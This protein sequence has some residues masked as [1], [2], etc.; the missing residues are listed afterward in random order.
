MSLIVTMSFML[1]F[2][3]W[4]PIL[5]RLGLVLNSPC[6]QAPSWMQE[7]RHRIQ[8]ALGVVRTIVIAV[9]SVA[10]VWSKIAAVLALV[11]IVVDI[12]NHVVGTLFRCRVT[13]GEAE[14]WGL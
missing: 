12:G 1:L 4:L 2:C 14:R 7:A 8:C 6:F 10:V 3:V 9:A 11:V 5:I 13:S